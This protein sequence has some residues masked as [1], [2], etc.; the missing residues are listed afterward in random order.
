MFK[1]LNSAAALGKGFLPTSTLLD[2]GLLDRAGMYYG[3]NANAPIKLFGIENLYGNGSVF[4]PGSYMDA[5][6]NLYVL[7]PNSTVDYA[8]TNSTSGMDLIYTASKN[9]T[10][11]YPS[12]VYACNEMGFM[13]PVTTG[14]SATTYFCNKMGLRQLQRGVRTGGLNT[15]DDI[16][17]FA[18]NFNINNNRM[19]NISRFVY[20]K[21]S[22]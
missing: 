21:R 12:K 1:N 3:E 4:L 17:M 16:G 18:A 10:L 5:K 13:V 9:Y 14:G 20:Y 15:D 19:D 22:E 7:N 2:T 11:N 6:Y 8:Y